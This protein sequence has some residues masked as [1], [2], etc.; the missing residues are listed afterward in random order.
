M[1]RTFFEGVR[2]GRVSRWIWYPS[3]QNNRISMP[4]LLSATNLNKQ[5]MMIFLAQLHHSPL[6]FLTCTSFQNLLCVAVPPPEPPATALKSCPRFNSSACFRRLATLASTCCALAMGAEGGGPEAV[7]GAT[8][9]GLGGV[10][11]IARCDGV[12]EMG[13]CLHINCL[14]PTPS[15]EEN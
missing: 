10:V 11:E 8:V 13:R 12:V 14:V 15:K 7:M 9:A 6:T 5:N 2:S 3:V 1:V 4:H